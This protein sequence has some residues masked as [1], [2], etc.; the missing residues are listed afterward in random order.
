MV[1]A[2]TYKYQVVTCPLITGLTANNGIF[3]QTLT[4]MTKEGL[5]AVKK[6]RK[7]SFNL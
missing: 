1:T 2:H 5:Q 4:K 7:Y 6:R 3:V